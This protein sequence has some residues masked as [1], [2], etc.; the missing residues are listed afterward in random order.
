M[1]RPLSRYEQDWLESQQHSGNKVA[2]LFTLESGSRPANIS[3]QKRYCRSVHS[4]DLLGD[5]SVIYA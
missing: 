4:P 5:H 2:V 1:H 3:V